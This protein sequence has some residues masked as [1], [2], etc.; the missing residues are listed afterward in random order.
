VLRQALETYDQQS[1]AMAKGVNLDTLIGA[2]WIT[3]K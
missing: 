3:F 2:W 1:L